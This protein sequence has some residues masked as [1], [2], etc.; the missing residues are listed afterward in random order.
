[1]PFYRT[2]SAVL[3]HTHSLW[4]QVV[5]AVD[6][7]GE[8]SLRRELEEAVQDKR[9]AE[10]AEAAARIQLQILKTTHERLKAEMLST[11]AAAAPAQ[12]SVSFEWLA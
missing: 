3:A 9:R 5:K 2:C 6:T 7:S 11:P 12:V 1:M 8:E 10:R 4:S